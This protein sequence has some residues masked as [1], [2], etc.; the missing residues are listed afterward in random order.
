MNNSTKKYFN[1]EVVNS[2]I[3]SIASVL[4]TF[5]YLYLKYTKGKYCDYVKV[6]K[7][8]KTGLEVPRV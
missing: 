3:D 7:T 4:F 2:S 1:A 8:K 6:K 5:T